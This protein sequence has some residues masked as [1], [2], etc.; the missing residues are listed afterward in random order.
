MLLRGYTLYLLVP[1]YPRTLKLLCRL[2]PHI[3]RRRNLNI[4][5]LNDL[6]EL[7]DTLTEISLKDT[8][9]RNK[10]VILDDVLPIRFFVGKLWDEDFAKRIGL[11][12]SLLGML[13]ED[14]VKVILT[15]PE[16]DNIPLPR[17]WSAFI[18]FTD[19]FYRLRRR[20]RIRELFIVKPLN[21]SPEG[22]PWNI[23]LSNL[24][25]ETILLARLYPMEYGFSLIEREEPS[26]NHRTDTQYN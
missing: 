13:L 6:D 21:L 18:E 14:K 3:K 20:G 4:Y 15:L 16:H 19:Y 8:K 22:Y 24:E 5:L 10:A 7:I 1:N 17:R 26:D 2:Y 12:F 9:E 25:L 11:M 23:S